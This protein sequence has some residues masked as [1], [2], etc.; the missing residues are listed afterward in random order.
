MLAPDVMALFILNVTENASTFLTMN[1]YSTSNPRRIINYRIGQKD[2]GG[3]P[4]SSILAVSVQ[5]DGV[6]PQLNPVRICLMVIPD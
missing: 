5:L 2:I 3:A 6:V 1:Q 4:D